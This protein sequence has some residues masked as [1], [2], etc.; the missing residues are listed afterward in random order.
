MG[1]RGGV[2]ANIAAMNAV[3]EAEGLILVGDRELIEKQPDIATLLARGA[4]IE[5]AADW[6]TGEESLNEVLRDRPQASMAVCARLVKSADAGGMVSSGDTRAL[7]ALTRRYLGTLPGLQ[8]P[9]IAKSF[10]GDH[11]PF[12]MLDLGANI[13]CSAELLVQFAKLGQTIA[14]LSDKTVTP[15]VALLNIGTEQG[16]GPLILIEAAA[17]IQRELSGLQWAGFVEPNELFDG[18]A[19][20]V[21]CDGFVGNLLLKTLEGTAMY[22]G[23]TIRRGLLGGSWLSKLG[24]SLARPDI[25]AIHD[26]LDPQNYNGALL[27][28]IREGVVV[29]SHGSTGAAGFRNAVQQTRAY[30]AGGLVT[31]LQDALDSS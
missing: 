12:W 27:A 9:A 10:T 8:R 13:E 19:D 17:R 1:G 14:V 11:G 4:R 21:V 18:K 22:L 26:E 23:R 2:S 20:I 16:K 28:G 5:H 3:V 15:R 24:V 7:M 31:R 25:E 6:L 30:V 29:K